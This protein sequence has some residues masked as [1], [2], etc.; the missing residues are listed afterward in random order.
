MRSNTW[1]VEPALLLASVVHGLAWTNSTDWFQNSVPESGEKPVQSQEETRHQK[2]GGEETNQAPTAPSAPDPYTYYVSKVPTEKFNAEVSKRT[3]AGYKSETGVFTYF[4]T[5]HVEERLNVWEIDPVTVAVEQAFGDWT[6]SNWKSFGYAF[7]RSVILKILPP[8]QED[9]ERLGVQNYSVLLEFRDIRPRAVL[10]GRG[11]TNGT[12]RVVLKMPN[13]E[14]GPVYA[15]L[16]KSPGS[17]EFDIQLFIVVGVFREKDWRYETL[18]LRTTLLND[19]FEGRQKVDRWPLRPLPFQ[20]F[21]DCDECE[22]HVPGSV[23]PA[24]G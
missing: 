14:V 15:S 16:T 10:T 7:G 1:V 9:L 20:I 3:P 6:N 19:S 17:T 8:K 12:P 13:D 11:A 22:P 2:P 23:Q 18:E 21:G 4:D 24:S 5:N